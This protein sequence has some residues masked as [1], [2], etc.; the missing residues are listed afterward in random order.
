MPLRQ[1]IFSQV[2][3]RTLCIICFLLINC[4]CT[5]RCVFLKHNT[6][7]TASASNC[8][9]GTVTLLLAHE[10]N[11]SESMYWSSGVRRSVRPSVTN[12]NIDNISDTIKCRIRNLGQTV[13]L[14]STF[15]TIPILLTLTKCQGH[16]LRSKMG[17]MTDFIDIQAILDTVR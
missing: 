8:I 5:S 1:D 2:S 11:E 14:H 9:P 16:R 15:N 3:E 7:I 10:C 6:Y 12:L 4:I 13:V 17:E